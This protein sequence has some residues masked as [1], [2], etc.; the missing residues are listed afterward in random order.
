TLHKKYDWPKKYM[1]KRTNMPATFGHL[2]GGYDGQYYE[3]LWSEVFSMD[4][5]Y[6]YFKKEG[7]MN[8]EVGIKYRNLILKPG[9]SLDDMDMLQNFLKREPNQKVLLMSLGLCA[10]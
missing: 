9:G 3:Y 7:I 4:M 1:K 5:F 8:P 10:P 2:A 6:S